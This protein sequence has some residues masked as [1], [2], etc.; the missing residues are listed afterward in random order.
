MVFYLFGVRF[1]FLSNQLISDVRILILEQD[2]NMNEAQTDVPTNGESVAKKTGNG[3]RKKYILKQL[4]KIWLQGSSRV[5]DHDDQ[6]S[7]SNL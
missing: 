7:R 4:I 3:G 2:K 5:M 6:Q 1:K